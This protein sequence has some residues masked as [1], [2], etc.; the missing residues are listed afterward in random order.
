MFSRIKK[1]PMFIKRFFIY[2][3]TTGVKD[4]GGSR[5]ARCGRCLVGKGCPH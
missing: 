1:I 4:G 5:C 2:V 3:T